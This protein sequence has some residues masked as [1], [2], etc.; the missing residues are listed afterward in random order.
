MSYPPQPAAGTPLSN[1]G[2]LAGTNTMAIIALVFV[3]I[4]CPVSIV[5]GH[6]ALR[7][8]RQTGEGGESLAKAALILG[9]V[10]TGLAL[11]LGG[12]ALVGALIALSGS[13]GQ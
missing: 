12:I 9:Y 1:Q 13:S 5:L 3:W 2:Q 7:Q 4:F 8:I 11:L 6:I 10:F